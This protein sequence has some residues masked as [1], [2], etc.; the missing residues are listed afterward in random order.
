MSASVVESAGVEGRL[1][2]HEAVDVVDGD[3]GTGVTMVNTSCQYHYLLKLDAAGRPRKLNFE[4]VFKGKLKAPNSYNP[5]SVSYLRGKPLM[6]LTGSPV[7]P[8]FISV[9]LLLESPPMR[10]APVGRA[11]AEC[12]TRRCLSLRE[13]LQP[14]SSLMQVLKCPP[15]MSESPLARLLEH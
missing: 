1:V 5:Y 12:L 10:R 15:S 6:L 2:L 11:Q 9:V 14:S 4:V 3:P 7:L 8:F 13:R